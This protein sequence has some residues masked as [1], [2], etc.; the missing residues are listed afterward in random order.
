M[1]KQA[2]KKWLGIVLMVSFVL[3][4]ILVVSFRIISRK[5]L[6][7]VAAAHRTVQLVTGQFTIKPGDL[8]SY[9]F[10]VNEQVFNGHI[11]GQFH[12][13]RDRRVLVVDELKL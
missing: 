8:S 3:A 12:P 10:E 13:G 7:R 9:P 4:L 1:N 2:L 5:Q 6:E 11:G